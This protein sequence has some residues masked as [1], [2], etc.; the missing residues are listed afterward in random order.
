MC[1]YTHTHTYTH[2]TIQYNTTFGFD[3]GPC[4]FVCICVCVC[5]RMLTR[6]SYL[7][8]CSNV[9]FPMRC[10]SGVLLYVLIKQVISWASDF[11]LEFYNFE[12]SSSNPTRD[13]DCSQS[14]NL[15][16][17]I[18]VSDHN[19]SPWLSRI[20]GVN[21][22]QTFANLCF[23]SRSARY[24][25]ATLLGFLTLTHA[26]KQD[27]VCPNRVRGHFFPPELIAILA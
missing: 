15:G 25:A 18:I 21:C 17:I 8:P 23:V 6:K 26:G 7:C 22:D 19:L 11:Y 16:R 10:C 27:T 5:V 13:F 3:A 20:F 2:T 14:L 24:L 12:P 4:V 9:I 1:Q